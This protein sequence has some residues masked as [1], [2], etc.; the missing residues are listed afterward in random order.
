MAASKTLKF[1]RPTAKDLNAAEAAW[2]DGRIVHE[3]PAESQFWRVLK[4]PTPGEA[5]E[6]ARVCYPSDV[7]SRF[8]PVMTYGN[9]VPAAYAG[10]T[11]EIAL[12]EA[13]LRDIHH[14]RIKRVPQR[15]V[16]NCY[17]IEA[18][19]TR[20]LNLLNL[21]RPYH[22]NIVAGR[23]RHPQ[24]SA[25]PAS[26][27][28]ITRAWAQALYARIPEIDGFLYESFQVPGDCI[29]LLQPTNIEVFNVQGTAHAVSD[30]PV[31]TLLRTEAHK[32]GAVIDFGHLLD[33]PVT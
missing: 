18:R 17:L 11:R 4:A 23:K 32:A 1:T 14:Q 30:E 25:A 10:S 29:L 27:Y 19:T 6:Y 24:L 33:P 13:V 26:A 9:I 31:R 7:R 21:R 5:V 28:D 20:S 12:W 3:V 15:A 8:S 2:R 16:S 22:A